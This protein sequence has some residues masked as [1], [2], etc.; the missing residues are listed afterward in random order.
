M[1]VH[2]RVL[3]QCVERERFDVADREPACVPP[4][5][6]SSP[7][8]SQTARGADLSGSAVPQ[9]NSVYFDYDSSQVK[10]D[11]ASVLA[12]HARYLSQHA[13]HRV[14]VEGNT[15]ERG[16]REYNLALGQQ[17]ADAVKQRLTLLGVP[18]QRIETVSFGEEKPRSETWTSRRT[19][20]TAARTSL[21][22]PAEWRREGQSMRACDSFTTFSYLS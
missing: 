14:R 22:P 12:A 4:I 19:P 7:A 3:R 11:S 17:R 16:S 18:G 20:R 13:D 6:R 2:A 15:D 1:F 10:E 5:V 21:T 9:K 8:G